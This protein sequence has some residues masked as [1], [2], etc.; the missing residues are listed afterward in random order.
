MSNDKKMTTDILSTENKQLRAEN[1]RLRNEKVAG[2]HAES[3]PG[4]VESFPQTS[5][6]DPTSAV[7]EWRMTPSDWYQGACNENCKWFFSAYEEC[8]SCGKPIKLTE[9]KE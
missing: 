2:G 9:A 5:A 4:E 3:V 6:T 8:P 7:C 1:E